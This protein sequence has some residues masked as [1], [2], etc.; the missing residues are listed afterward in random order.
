ML[1]AD[2]SLAAHGLTIVLCGK[3]LLRLVISGNTACTLRHKD[4]VSSPKLS[5]KIDQLRY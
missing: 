1:L 5:S 4:A 2:D 3:K